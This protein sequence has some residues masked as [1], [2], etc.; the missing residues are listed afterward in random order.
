M[1][2][3]GRYIPKGN[4]ESYAAAL[5][6]RGN[7]LR[8]LKR[9]WW[10]NVEGMFLL[11]LSLVNWLE[12]VHF[13]DYYDKMCS[14]GWNAA[15]GKHAQRPEGFYFPDYIHSFPGPLTHKRER[16]RAKER[17]GKGEVIKLL[18][19]KLTKVQRGHFKRSVITSKN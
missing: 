2:I 16:Q 9:K 15:N 13:S 11:R 18:A 1:K 6:K 12:N 4:S 5:Y 8:I 14:K 10:A 19:V 3:K 7:Y 17:K